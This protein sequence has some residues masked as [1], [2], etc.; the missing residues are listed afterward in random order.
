MTTTNPV[1]SA[2]VDDLVFNA[3]KLDEVINSSSGLY[4]D[5]LGVQRLTATGATNRIAAL[6]PRGAWVTATLYQP[7]DLVLDSGTWYVALDT[8]TSGATFAGDLAA[9]WRP[10]Q[11]VTSADLLDTTTAGKGETKVGQGAITS[12]IGGVVTR[13]A[14]IAAAIAAIGATPAL[15]TI[16]GAASVAASASIPTTTSVR[17][18]PP[19][20]INVASGQTLTINGS[21]EADQRL[22]FTGS[23]SVVFG[24]K[25][26]TPS[27]PVWTEGATA[28]S[29]VFSQ[30][31]TLL[32][33]DSDLSFPVHGF[34]DRNTLNYTTTPVS[35]AS[36]Y[37]TFDSQTTM[38]G[39]CGYD[40]MV[41]YQARQTYSGSVSLGRFDHFNSLHTHNGAGTVNLMR[42]V[43]IENPLGSGPINNLYGVHV[44]RL[45]R[46]GITYG[47]YSQTAM[48]VVSVNAG[49]SASWLLRGNGQTDSFGL[50]LQS[51]GDSSAR[52]L[53]TAN[54]SLRFGVNN[55]DSGFC[56]PAAGGTWKLNGTS[57][58]DVLSANQRLEVRGAG[59]ATFAASGAAGV[60]AVLTWHQATTGDNIFNAFYTE[61]SA[62]LRGSIDY[63]RGGTLTRYNT[64]CDANLKTLIGDAPVEKSVGILMRTRLREF[65]WNEDGTKKPQIAPFAQELYEVF[66]GAVSIGGEYEEIV[67]GE[68]V[69]RY[70]PWAVDKTAFTFHLIAGW[71]QHERR[72]AELEALVKALIK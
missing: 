14:T 49:E 66:K 71:Q 52:V 67:N 69:R 40:H 20:T 51:S 34:E 8:H 42:G 61:G 19:G 37:A 35:L 56:L 4:V 63:N 23:G 39:S 72:I 10:E 62:T 27:P 9:H 57:S 60:G 50:F 38:T 47:F 45:D 59:G 26:R 25:S 53:N 13:H 7:R 17:V 11:G 70:R 41:A 3:Q 24:S 1:P 46:G 15:L 48:N 6:N 68:K 31:R 16:R 54:A 18:E 36:A 65:F 21:F 28:A 58:A 43:H 2:D 32:Q 5:R 12:T 44:E 33:S 22:I 64:T 55:A 30:K 29:A